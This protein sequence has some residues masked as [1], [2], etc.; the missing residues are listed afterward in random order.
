MKSL[1][2]SILE[3]DAYEHK[4]AIYNWEKGM[5][6]SYSEIHGFR[7]NLNNPLF[8]HWIENDVHHI[9][10]LV[11][12][13]KCIITR[14]DPSTSIK[15]YGTKTRMAFD[16]ILVIPKMRIYNAATIKHDQIPY[17]HDIIEMGENVLHENY[18]RASCATANDALSFL[19]MVSSQKIEKV[20]IHDLNASLVIKNKKQDR[21]IKQCVHLFPHNSVGQLH[22]HMWTQGLETRNDLSH[23]NVDIFKILDS[24]EK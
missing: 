15:E 24:I 17:I 4:D 12:N 1:Q 3:F 16:H 2:A 9:N 23:I 19:A 13:D 6:G 7:E 11:D 8:S 20:S 18:R 5:D 22:I 14:P 21:V 10:T